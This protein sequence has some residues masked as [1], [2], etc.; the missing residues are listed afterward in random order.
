MSGRLRALIV[1][2]E[3]LARLGL[4]QLAEAHGGLTV[5]G[6]C[7]NG[8]DALQQLDGAAPDV[9]FLDVQMPGLDGFG[10][11][12]AR[13]PERMPLVVFVTAFDEYAV[14]AFEAHALDY[15]VKPVT[16]SRFAAAV[17]RVREQLSGRQALAAAR[18][19]G[20]LVTPEGPLR[21]SVPTAAGRLLLDPDEV[22]WIGADDYYAAVHAAGR[23]HLVR[24]SLDSLEARLRAPFLRVHRSAIVNVARVR[25]LRS[26]SGRAVVVLRD[27]TEVAVSRRRREA[28]ADALRRLSA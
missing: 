19:L 11:I 28:V 7:R 15:L 2:D 26:A 12:R 25:E 4:R 9:V 13:G 8:R 18:R 17:A 20:A 16:A 24:E 21:L 3:P 27:G 14:R 6:E 5:V 1:D 22:D 10:V 23:R